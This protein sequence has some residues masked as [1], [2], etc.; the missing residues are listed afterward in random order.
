MQYVM[1]LYLVISLENEYHSQLV[2]GKFLPY[3][4]ILVQCIAQQVSHL[5]LW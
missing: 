2:Q 4:P 1:N 5:F 3:W